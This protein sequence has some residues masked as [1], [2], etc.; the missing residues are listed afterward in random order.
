M[1]KSNGNMNES[2]YMI[3]YGVTNFEHAL[4]AYNYGLWNFSIDYQEH[5]EDLIVFVMGDNF[6]KIVS[7][8]VRGLAMWVI[9]LDS[10]SNSPQ[11]DNTVWHQQEVYHNQQLTLHWT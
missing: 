5:N 10:F 8:F 2:K 9:L 1:Q 11:I 6:S 7:L 4:E 3:I